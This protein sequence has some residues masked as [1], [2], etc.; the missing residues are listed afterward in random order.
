MNDS[1]VRPF[2]R[3]FARFIDYLL[4]GMLAVVVLGDRIGSVHNPSRAFYLSFWVYPF[5]EAVLIS[6]FG[7]TFGK[8]LAGIRVL[9]ENG[10]RLALYLSLKRAFL[11]FGAGMGCFLSYISLLFPILGCYGLVKYRTTVWDKYTPAVVFVEKTTVIDKLVLAVFMTFLASGYL[12]TVR[13][14]TRPPPDLSFIEDMFATAYSEKIRPVMLEALSENTLLY[15]DQ[16]AAAGQTLQTVQKM[17]DHENRSFARIHNGIQDRIDA[18]PFGPARRRQQEALNILT[19]RVGSFLFT[20][21]IRASLFE[22]ILG[23]FQSAENKYQMVD[24]RPVFTDE[25]LAR[26]YEI[27]MMQLEAFLSE[28]LPVAEPPVAIRN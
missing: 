9:D 5:F 14:L 28:G 22:N 16:V 23:F 3:A 2:R 20:E 27:Y 24:G 13:S 12:L 4:W 17:I 25:T 7:T 11:V 21:S 18:M 26:Q 10:N 15:P 6:L 1:G 8:R 19:D